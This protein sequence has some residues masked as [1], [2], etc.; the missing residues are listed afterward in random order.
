MKMTSVSGVF[1]RLGLNHFA[2]LIAIAIQYQ[3]HRIGRRQLLLAETLPPQLLE[4]FR[5][6]QQDVGQR[7]TEGWILLGMRFSQPQ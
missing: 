6:R 2:Q 7:G 5:R 3:D 1:L 4:R